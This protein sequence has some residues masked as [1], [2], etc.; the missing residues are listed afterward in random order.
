MEEAEL[1]TQQ[2]SPV[3]DPE[4][5][6]SPATVAAVHSSGGEE[7]SIQQLFRR[8]KEIRKAEIKE[9]LA[10]PLKANIMDIDKDNVTTR[11]LV[12]FIIDDDFVHDGDYRVGDLV[13]TDVKGKQLGV[14]LDIDQSAHLVTIQYQDGTV[15]DE[16]ETRVK[17]HSL[18]GVA[19]GLGSPS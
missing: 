17:L 5:T 15:A 12:E 11:D 7:E 14:V 8:K 1:S 16:P 19:A 4:S 3:G 9:L 13:W 2:V 18:P 10:M 6:G